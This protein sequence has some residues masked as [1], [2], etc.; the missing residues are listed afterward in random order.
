MSIFSA[1]AQLKVFRVCVVCVFL[2]YCGSASPRG[3]LC[4]CSGPRWSS[5]GCEMSGWRARGWRWSERPYLP[6]RPARGDA[7]LAIPW[8]CSDDAD[9]TALYFIMFARVRARRCAWVSFPRRSRT[10]LA[11]VPRAHRNSH[12]D[13]ELKLFR[14]SSVTKYTF[15]NAKWRLKLK[16]KLCLTR[17]GKWKLYQ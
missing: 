1:F 12:M 17:N 7:P 10:V 9:Q 2:L 4:V 16:Q 5:N 3:C 14:K 13:T 15:Q 11:F 6:I 8:V